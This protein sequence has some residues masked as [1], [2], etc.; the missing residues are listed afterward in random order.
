MNAVSLIGEVLAKP[1]LRTNR[2][3]IAECRMMLA[4]PRYS[5]AGIREPG[6]VYVEASTFGLEAQDH[7][8]RLSAGSR[9]GLAGRLNEAG[10]VLIDQLDVL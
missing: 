9:I 7:A 4:V 3:G 5:R 8:K 6:V 2:A 10:H 1:E